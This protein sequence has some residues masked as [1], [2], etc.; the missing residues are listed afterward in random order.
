MPE[1]WPKV[2]VSYGEFGSVLIRTLLVP[3]LETDADGVSESLGEAC[4]VFGTFEGT[5]VGLTIG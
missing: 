1:F 3:V 5:G 2:C 4:W